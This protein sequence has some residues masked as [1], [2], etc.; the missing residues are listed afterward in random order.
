MTEHIYLLNQFITILEMS[1][2]LLISV[3]L[4][5]MADHL[6][7]SCYYRYY[8]SNTAVEETFE[9]ESTQSNNIQTQLA[10]HYNIH[11]LPRG[12]NLWYYINDI[13]NIRGFMELLL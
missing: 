5:R 7:Y 12:N 11:V 8:Y 13:S 1:I 4:I 3:Y 9:S 10:A 2:A 6:W